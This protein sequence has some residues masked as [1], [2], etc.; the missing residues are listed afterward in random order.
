MIATSMLLFSSH[1]LPGVRGW[2]LRR[3]LGKNYLKI[4]DAL[5]NRLNSI[6]LRVKIVFDQLSSDSPARD[7]FDKARFFVTLSEPLSVADIVAAGWN[8]EDV[9]IL[10]AVFSYI[11][12]KGGKASEKELVELLEIK[13]PRQRVEAVIERFTK[14]GYLTKF[15]DDMIKVGWR[16]L[17]EVDEKEL[18]K[19]ITE[20]ASPQQN[21]RRD[22]TKEEA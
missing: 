13:F 3:R 5:N 8:I 16:T 6:G 21:Q 10:A 18:L 19:A 2:E 4:I 14:K 9:A 1:K 12:T 11:F 20:I 17:A 22:N 7:D 15:E